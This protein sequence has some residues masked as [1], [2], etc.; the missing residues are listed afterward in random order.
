MA[1]RQMTMVGRIATAP[2]VVILFIWMIVPL[3]M[4]IWFSLQRYNL[5]YP[6][7]RG[8]VG[9]NN[10]VYFLTDPAFGSIVATSIAS[11]VTAPSMIT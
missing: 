11:Q 2:S 10:Y 6:E 9:I 1:T 8:F 5:L 3:A 4:T 7:R